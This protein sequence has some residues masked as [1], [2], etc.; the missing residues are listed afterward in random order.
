[1]FI[2]NREPHTWAKEGTS[3]GR[4]RET[5]AD[6]RAERRARHGAGSQDPDLMTWAE[7]KSL[8]V[9]QTE[10]PRCPINAKQILYKKS[11]CG[12]IRKCKSVYSSW[13][14]FQCIKNLGILLDWFWF[15]NDF[16]TSFFLCSHET[17][18]ELWSW[19]SLL[20]RECRG[21]GSQNHLTL[22]KRDLFPC[23]RFSRKLA[24]LTYENTKSN[25]F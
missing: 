20:L 5:P 22:G 8:E 14:N 15:W 23:Y 10:P 24:S 11:S 17:E 3:R 19:H 9:Q 18:A 13:A 7:T 25:V 4:G 21:Q 12:F 1:M 6:S 16:Q 2:W